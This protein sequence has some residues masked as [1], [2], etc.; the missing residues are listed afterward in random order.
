[1]VDIISMVEMILLGVIGIAL[2]IFVLA[3]IVYV[4]R[5][6]VGIKTKRMFGAKMPQGQIIARNGE[7][8]IQADTLMPGLY[9]FS[10]VTWK[11]EKVDITY[12]KETEVGT[13]ESIDGEPITTG[14]LLGDAVESNQFQ[15]AKTFL[16]NGGNKGPQIAILRPGAYR[17]NTR[18][19]TVTKHNVTKI[20]EESIGIVVAVDGQPL[21]SGYIIA[22]K[23]ANDDH[24]FFSYE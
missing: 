2:V 13:I 6:K 11:I 7:I 17:I 4:S 22:P 21:P 16:D 8:G 3:G 23:P 9:W 14:R 1:M 10:P 18:T 20:P 12:I 5:Y 24:K 19:F 15:D